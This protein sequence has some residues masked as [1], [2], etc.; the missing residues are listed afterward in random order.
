MPSIR[1][2]HILILATDGFEQ[3]ELTVPR[4]ELRKKGAR[5]DV[6]TPT[7]RS[8]RGW[9]KNDWGETA[10]AD[11]ISRSPTPSRTTMTRS[12][13]PAVSSIRTNYELMTARCASS[14]PS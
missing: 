2:A 5:V 10:P 1:D 12:F 9:D 8:I 11:L 3:R 4:D 6:A 7:G 14:S 13:C